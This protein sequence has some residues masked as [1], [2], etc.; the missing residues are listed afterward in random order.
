[1]KVELKTVSMETFESMR[2]LSM[3]SPI[4][5]AMDDHKKTPLK[6]PRKVSVTSSTEEPFYVLTPRGKIAL[7]VIPR[8]PSA[9]I[10]EILFNYAGV[11]IQKDKVVRLTDPL[12]S[13]TL[14]Y[15]PII[16]PSSA[17]RFT[18]ATESMAVL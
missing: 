1:M 8:Y 5:H 3:V 16:P 11:T 10:R 12:T 4:M 9:A 2:A 6:I 14:Y 18:E 15:S 13:D 17:V 7:L